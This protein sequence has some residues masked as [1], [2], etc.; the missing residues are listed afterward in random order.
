M[1]TPKQMREEYFINNPLVY[2]QYCQIKDRNKS[3]VASEEAFLAIK[4]YAI[5]HTLFYKK[6]SLKD[7]FP[8]MTKLD[9]LQNKAAIISDEIFDKPLHTASTSG[10]TGIPF[11]VVQN[12]EKRM[13]TVADLKVFGE[14]ALYPSHEKMLQL[15][16]YNGR[17]LDR[18]VD[19]RENIWRY[20][21][22][23]LS[24]EHI[25]NL[26]GFILE[27]KPN[28]IFGYASTLETI[29]SYI[30]KKGREY[31]FGCKSVLVGAEALTDEI[32]HKIKS[33]FRCPVFDRYS[34]MEMGI[35]AQREH[36][37]TKFKVNN[38]SYYLEVLKLDCD[39][40]ADEHEI[41][42]LV[43]TDLYNRA[44]PMIR[45]DTGDV[46][47]YCVNNGV[48]EIEAVYGRKVD[49]IYDINHNLI[50]PHSITNAMWGISGIE[51]WQ[52]FQKGENYYLLK[53]KANSKVNELNV[54]E[55]LHNSLG[56]KADIRIEY[57][58]DIPTLSSQKRKYIVNET[59]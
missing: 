50:S 37:K 46:G 49:C 14:Y 5:E 42:R 18:S 58:F 2:D 23:Y 28:T 40:A 22:S 29:S 26:I 16:A 45:Y 12:Y 53:I 15:R 20:D 38:A 30:M 25:E 3:G 13:R 52:F 31:N 56:D 51:Q 43:F 59:Y 6:Y 34:N 4:K 27:W 32:A 24:D 17:E 44:F 7:K 8:I 57:V 39:E 10:S 21:I 35:Y 33:V 1:K 41:G 11:S 55:R 36:G 19:E 9:F 54:L 47:S 48:I